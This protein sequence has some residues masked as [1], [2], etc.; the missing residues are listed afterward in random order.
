V[1]CAL[2]IGIGV[3]HIW[4]VVP[5]WA[6]VSHVVVGSATITYIFAVYLSARAKKSISV[7]E[8]NH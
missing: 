8:S 4:F 2:Q 1:L 6:Q 5:A 3:V 7:D